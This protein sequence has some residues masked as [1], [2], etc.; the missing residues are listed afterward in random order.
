M[1]TRTKVGAYLE[2]TRQVVGFSAAKTRTSRKTSLARH[3]KAAT[4]RA[5]SEALAAGAQAFHSETN[6]RHQV[7]SSRS[8]LYSAQPQQVAAAVPQHRLSAVEADSVL[9]SKRRTTRA[10]H[11]P[12]GRHYSGAWVRSPLPRQ[13][14]LPKASSRRAV[15]VADCS[16]LHRQA[17]HPLLALEVA[18][19]ALAT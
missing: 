3:H 14:A 6:L 17:Q 12:L 18:A 5:F 9:A 8:L 2:G 7:V 13:P 11:Q 15:Q 19:S 1:E 16:A 4:A 10:Q